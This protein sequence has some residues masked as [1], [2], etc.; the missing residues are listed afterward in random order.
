MLSIAV[1]RA[2]AIVVLLLALTACTRRQPLSTNPGGI[3]CGGATAAECATGQFCDLPAGKCGVAA[4]GGV[5]RPRTN[6]CTKDYRPVCGC[7]GKTYPS[8]CVRSGAGMQKDHEGECVRGRDVHVIGCPYSGK[9]A[10]CLMIDDGQGGTWDITAV[11]PQ[12]EIGK[13]VVS[14]A[15]TKGDGSGACGQGRLITNVTWTYTPVRCPTP[16]KKPPQP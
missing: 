7:D 16:K 9:Q 6:I 14:L 10:G 4:V 1:M 3:P 11:T 5:C 15:G 8:D 12:P 2:R 13:Q